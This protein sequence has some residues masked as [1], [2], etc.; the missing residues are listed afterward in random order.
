MKFLYCEGK[1][2]IMSNGVKFN[3]NR[4]ESLLYEDVYPKYNMYK[5]T[6]QQVSMTLISRIM[7]NSGISIPIHPYTTTHIPS[8]YIPV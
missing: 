4:A 3:E 5:N 1:K 2:I 6:D 7:S 8:Y